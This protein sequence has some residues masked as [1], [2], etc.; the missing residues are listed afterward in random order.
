MIIFISL[1]LISFKVFESA[2]QEFEEIPVIALSVMEN[3]QTGSRTELDRGD[4]QVDVVLLEDDFG[5][6]ALA[7]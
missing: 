3:L 5:P 4:V 1:V 6:S 7:K 2:F